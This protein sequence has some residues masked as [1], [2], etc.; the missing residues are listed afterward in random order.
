MIAVYYKSH[1]T[2]KYTVRAR[3]GVFIGKP[4]SIYMNSYQFSSN[5]LMLFHMLFS[6]HHHGITAVSGG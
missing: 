3:C 1:E 6:G 4:D 5:N 2:Y